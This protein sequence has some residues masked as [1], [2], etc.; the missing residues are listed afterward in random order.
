MTDGFDSNGLLH[1]SKIG[2]LPVTPHCVIRVPFADGAVVTIE[3]QTAPG[4]YVD[5]NLTD[6]EIETIRQCLGAGKPFMVTA[7]P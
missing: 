7:Q 4:V 5:M 2:P 3:R 6:T 1:L